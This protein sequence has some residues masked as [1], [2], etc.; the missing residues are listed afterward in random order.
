MVKKLSLFVC[1]LTLLG[2]NRVIE[3]PFGG[4]VF[5]HHFIS[6]LC[7]ATAID[8]KPFYQDHSIICIGHL[9][10]ETFFDDR[11]HQLCNEFGDNT[12]N[13][14]VPQDRGYSVCYANL[15]TSV[16]IYSS[17]DFGDIKAGESLA[18]I[19]MFRG[20]TAKPFIDNGYSWAGIM[21]RA[22]IEMFY[23]ELGEYRRYFE[24]QIPNGA[25]PVFKP[26]S[27]LTPEDL[28]LLCCPKVSLRFMELPEIKEHTLTIIF[29]TEETEIRGQVDVLFP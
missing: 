1:I 24:D 8:V 5:S 27:E 22:R 20:A 21:D 13:R 28:T 18:D 7:E 4:A 17:A 25:I 16:D 12:Y 9:P 26:V 29:R 11:Y 19:V 6:G 14:Y 10:E 15:F 23:A 2:C 3:Q